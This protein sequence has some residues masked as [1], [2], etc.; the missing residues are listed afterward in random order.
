MKIE[1]RPL[2]D[3]PRPR[4]AATKSWKSG[5]TPKCTKNDQI[6][7]IYFLNT[8]YFHLSYTPFNAELNLE[9]F[10]L[11]CMFVTCFVLELLTKNRSENRRRN[12]A[13]PMASEKALFTL[14]SQIDQIVITKL[15][16]KK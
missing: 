15:S 6:R 11:I 4:F 14:H 13:D 3:R 16:N 12:F 1:K 7:Q 9:F 10:E 8:A 2:F 5:K